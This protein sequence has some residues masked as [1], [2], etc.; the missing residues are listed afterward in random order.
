VACCT[1]SMLVGM[2]I[3]CFETSGSWLQ[4]AGAGVSGAVLAAVL[5]ST[6]MVA[7]PSQSH[8]Q[9]IEP[10]AWT[11]WHAAQMRAPVAVSVKP[12]DEHIF[13]H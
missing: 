5:P 9:L 4:L 6:R 8:T 2:M 12:R 7:H 11:V 3:F 13:V 10:L 1:A